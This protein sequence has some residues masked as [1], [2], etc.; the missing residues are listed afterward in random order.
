MWNRTLL[1]RGGERDISIVVAR[2]NQRRCC[3]SRGG[4]H[5]LQSYVPTSMFQQVIQ[6][7]T[8]FYYW[9]QLQL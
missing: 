8:K 3:S 5:W 2:W 4:H 7:P 9:L 6:V 1:Q